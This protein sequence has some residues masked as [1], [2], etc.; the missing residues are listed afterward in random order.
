MPLDASTPAAT[1]GRLERHGD[2]RAASWTGRLPCRHPAVGAVDIVPC[3]QVPNPMPMVDPAAHGL[4]RPSDETGKR[5]MS[6]D[7]LV[8]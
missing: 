1:A 5:S 3:A 2:A 8:P 4:R 6:L 7:G